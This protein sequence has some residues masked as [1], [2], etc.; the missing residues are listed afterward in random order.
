VSAFPETSITLLGKLAAEVTGCD[1]ANWLRFWNLYA[2]AIRAFAARRGGEAD[3]DDAT[4]RVMAKLV[5]VFRQGRFDSARGNFR[6]YLAQMVRNE[7]GMIYR[8][9]VARHADRKVSLDAASGAEGVDSAAVRKAEA[10]MAL[11]AS[12][13]VEEMDLEWAAAR[14]QAILDHIYA[15]P[16]MNRTVLAIYRAYALEG[17]PIGEVATAFGTSR[18]NVS[19]IKSRM[20]KTIAGL[21]AEFGAEP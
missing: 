2:G 3:A 8:A 19:Q 9:K 11:P 20:E 14:R 17:K 7:V 6:A 18:N 12:S 5:D 15:N 1:D 21:A 13:V 16:T 10:A 4:A